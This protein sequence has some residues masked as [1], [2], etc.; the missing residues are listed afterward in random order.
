MNPFRVLHQSK[1][2]RARV[3]ELRTAHG[4]VRTPFFMTIATRGAVKT[5]AAEDM[6]EIGALAR[7]DAGAT[8]PKRSGG[9][10]G[11]GRGG[12]ILLSNTYHLYVRPGMEV[13]KKAGGLHKFMGW[14]GPILTDSGGYQV[15]SL[16]N[17]N[18][19]PSPVL[20]T[21]SPAGRGGS[22]QFPS[23]RGRGEGEGQ[24]YDVRITKDGAE[25][26]DRISGRKDM[27]TPERVLEIQKVIGSDIAMVLDVCAPYPISKEGAR[28]AME[29]TTSW[30]E[31]SM[32]V[33]KHESIKT[34]VFGIVQGSVYKDLREQSARDLVALDFD[35][36]AIGGVAVGEPQKEK[37][38]VVDW[39]APMLPEDKPR[40]LMGLGQPEEL[41]EAVRR[42]IDMF[43]CVLPTRN[44]RHGNLYVWRHN[45]PQPSLTLREGDRPLLPLR[46]RGS[47][48]GL[49]G[50]F[51]DTMRITNEKYRADFKPIDPY[52]E[53]F[54]CTH[55][56]RAYLRHL[57]K[58][59]EPLALRLA[60]IHNVKFY[61]DF[62]VGLQNAVVE[63]T[64]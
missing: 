20:R 49:R 61:L 4:K 29:R 43:D 5:L 27:F 23:P 21:P 60:T 6:R 58:I 7:R 28:E 63:G 56:S 48:R 59:N 17:K 39:V 46:V 2:S 31:R 3:G 57:F 30:A 53:C 16:A 9:M 62:M 24:D 51:Y 32:K 15:F 35:G 37:Y 55:H 42:G 22:N 19:N 1:K 41:V 64:L 34:L 54:T 50:N 44:A 26:I 18:R 38:Q 33:L 12:P 36:Y 45:P 14:N 40:Y 10:S 52:C 47:E 11:G 25:F 13:I 8:E